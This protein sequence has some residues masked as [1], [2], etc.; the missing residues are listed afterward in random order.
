[1][2]NV[3]PPNAPAYVSPTKRSTFLQAL[4]KQILL[5]NFPELHLEEAMVDAFIKNA[6]H[7]KFLRGRKV[8]EWDRQ[9]DDVGTPHAPTR[10]ID[11]LN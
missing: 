9:N 1:M 10:V 7:L 8:G 2:E 5:E 4:F 11:F 6:H 3:S